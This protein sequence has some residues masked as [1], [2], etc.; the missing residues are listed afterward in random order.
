MK[1]IFNAVML[2][3]NECTLSVIY[4][5]VTDFVNHI[6]KAKSNINV[7]LHSNCV[8]V[9]AKN[10]NDAISLIIDV[11][12]FDKSTLP[13]LYDDVCKRV[14]LSE[15]KYHCT[16][17]NFEFLKNYDYKKLLTREN[18]QKVYDLRQE[19][20]KS[21]LNWEEKFVNVDKFTKES[22]LSG[23]YQPKTK[24]QIQSDFMN[25]IRGE[26]EQPSK[27]IV[28]KNS[29]DIGEFTYEELRVLKTMHTTKFILDAKAKSGY[30]NNESG[31]NCW[32][33]SNFS[34]PIITNKKVQKK[35]TKKTQENKQKVI[36]DFLDK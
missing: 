25:V 34:K 11:K 2:G 16:I 5:I 28:F 12:S 33:P 13:V 30:D 23:E 31:L 21:V 29:V 24:Y 6:E 14:R 20:V 22:I 1:T 19:L 32:M 3:K 35:V 18:E 4:D 27:N 26:I 36:D 7:I 9:I 8:E 10:D 17:S 15:C